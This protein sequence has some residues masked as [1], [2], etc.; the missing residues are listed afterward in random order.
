MDPKR[1]RQPPKHARAIA[2]T[3]TT[4]S[5]VRKGRLDYALDGLRAAW[6][7]EAGFRNHVFGAAAML[8]TLIIVDPAA[9]WW[10]VALFCSSVLIALELVNSAIERL[11]DHVDGRIHPRIKAIKDMS[12]AA[13]VAASTGVFLLGVIMIADTL[14]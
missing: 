4:P 13:V 9:I 11:I 2:S 7:E 10:A 12:A 3:R 14:T 8:A 6:R 5:P 1:E